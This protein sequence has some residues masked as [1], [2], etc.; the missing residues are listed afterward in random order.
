[1]H[2]GGAHSTIFRFQITCLEIKESL[3]GLE[4]WGPALTA[5]DTRVLCVAQGTGRETPH[6]SLRSPYHWVGCGRPLWV[7]AREASWV[8]FL[9]QDEARLSCPNSAGTLRSQSE[10]ERTHL[11]NYSFLPNKLY[12]IVG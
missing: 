8:P 2:V 9:R 1:M 5:G 10:T 4:Q 6:L 7:S 12:Y 3:G 11:S